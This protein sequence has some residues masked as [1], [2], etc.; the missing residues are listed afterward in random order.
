MDV[1]TLTRARDDEP[2][3]LR[4]SSSLEAARA[5]ADRQD[6]VR[7]AKEPSAYPE[8]GIGREIVGHLDLDAGARAC[9]IERFRLDDGRPADDYERE[10]ARLMADGG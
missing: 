6:D 4:V 3:I 5:P 7:R 1:R 10:V 9:G 8:M 2:R